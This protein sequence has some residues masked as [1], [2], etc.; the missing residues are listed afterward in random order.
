M[1]RQLG[2]RVVALHR[3]RIMQ[4]TLEGL[5]PGEWKD[6]SDEER[7]R[8]FAALGRSETKSR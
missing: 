2:Y 5:G 8:L 6:L 1:C 4:T 7:E 3:V